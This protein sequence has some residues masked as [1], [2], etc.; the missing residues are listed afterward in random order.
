MALNIPFTVISAVCD[1]PRACNENEDCVAPDVCVC[2]DHY[3]GA[4]CQIRKYHYCIL[5]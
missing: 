2:K 4:D 5:H 1:S 3:G